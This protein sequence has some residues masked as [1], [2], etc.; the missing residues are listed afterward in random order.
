MLA[1]LAVAVDTAVTV[2]ILALVV[3]ALFAVLAVTNF[4]AVV[5]DVFDLVV[6]LVLRP[7]CLLVG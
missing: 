1:V 2:T 4:V 6:W 7:D 5:V 3:A